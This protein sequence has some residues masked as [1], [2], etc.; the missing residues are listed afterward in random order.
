MESGGVIKGNVSTEEEDGG[1]KE[2][3][4]LR[5]RGLGGAGSAPPPPG[6]GG[7]ETVCN[8]TF[9]V[10]HMQEKCSEERTNNGA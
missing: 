10:Y 3:V 6:G 9:T 4:N 2:A 8:P 1:G 5:K 7:G